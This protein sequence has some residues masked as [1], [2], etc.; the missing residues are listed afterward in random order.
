ML[1]YEIDESLEY[2]GQVEYMGQDGTL[3]TIERIEDNNFKGI[4]EARQ[5]ILEDEEEI[6]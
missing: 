6:F 4:V 3:H 5:R 1:N 2:M